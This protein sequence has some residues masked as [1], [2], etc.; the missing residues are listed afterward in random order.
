VAMDEGGEEQMV[1]DGEEGDYV[2]EG[3]WIMRAFGRESR[4]RG[5]EWGP[6]RHQFLECLAQ[7]TSQTPGAL[8]LLARE[9]GWT[10][11]VCSPLL[12]LSSSMQTLQSSLIERGVL[13]TVW[14]DVSCFA[15]WQEREPG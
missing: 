4:R 6:A 10:M 9:V 8:D 7:H 1:Y 3:E 13:R 5:P 2:D 11:S 14:V 15:D 12:C